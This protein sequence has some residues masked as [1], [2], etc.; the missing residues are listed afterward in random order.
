MILIKFDR[1]LFVCI[2]WATDRM[3]L[4]NRIRIYPKSFVVANVNIAGYENETNDFE[5]F[6]MRKTQ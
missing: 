3:C 1:R 2:V 6:R 4:H 5:S